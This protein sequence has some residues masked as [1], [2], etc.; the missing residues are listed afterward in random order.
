MASSSKRALMQKSLYAQ[1][2]R[3]LGG[4][5]AAEANPT[6]TATNNS[7]VH[8]INNAISGKTIDDLDGPTG[9][10]IVGNFLTYIKKENQ[11]RMHEVQV[12]IFVL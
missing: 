6:L 11:G 12:Y 4:A 10:P 7:T 8:A 5:A 1:L 3:S 2:K 9:W